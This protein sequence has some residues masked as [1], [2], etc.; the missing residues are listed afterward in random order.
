MALLRSYNI[1]EMGIFTMPS[2]IYDIVTNYIG[3]AA[4]KQIGN[5]SSSAGNLIYFIPITKGQ[6][7]S[8]MEQKIVTRN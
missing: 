1:L 7:Y 8:I 5:P 4:K 6:I 2:N 3:G